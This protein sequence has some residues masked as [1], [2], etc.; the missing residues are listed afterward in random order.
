[1]RLNSM[2]QIS[3]PGLVIAGEARCARLAPTI[4][5]ASCLL[6]LLTAC[7]GKQQAH[8]PKQPASKPTF[9]VALLRT[10]LGLGD[11]EL[12]RDAD[13][14]LQKLEDEGHII[15]NPVGER[16]PALASEGGTGDVGLPGAE[17]KPGA[18]PVGMMTL[19]EVV[20][21]AEQ[22]EKVDHD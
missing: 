14:A 16:P 20:K 1:M 19:D 18:K 7:P 9:T 12:V 5:A 13:A 10:D 2:Q 4:L 17:L 6:L 8:K 21:L 11:G 3:G 22:L 15:Y